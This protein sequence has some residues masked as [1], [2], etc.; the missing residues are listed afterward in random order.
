LS[1]IQGGV[2]INV[3]TQRRAVFFQLNV[4]IP[5]SVGY[6]AMISLKMTITTPAIKPD[7]T[8]T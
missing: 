7:E 8:G 3:G 6:N 4:T 5:V 2:E 1:P